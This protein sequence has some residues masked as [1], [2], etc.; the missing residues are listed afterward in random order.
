MDVFS[1]LSLMGGLAL[2]L[3]GMHVLGAGLEKIAGGKLERILEKMT[4]SPLKGVLLGAAVTAVIQSSSATTVMV[5][6]FVNS[7]IM[8]LTQSI[9][10][11]M[12][13]NIGTTVTAW[14]LSLT[15]LEGD[16]LLV[17]LLKP[18]SFTPVLA[19]IGIVLLLFVKRGRKK[20][21]G[22]TL[23][24]FAVLMFGM[25]MMS[26]S[27]KGLADV[28]AFQDL[29][30]MFQNPIFGVLVGAVVTAV[31]QSSSASV[32]ILQALSATGKITYGAAIPIILGQNIGTCATALISCIGANKNAKRAAMVHLYFNLI[33]TALFLALFYGLNALVDLAFIDNILNAAHIAVIHTLFNVLSTLVLL[34]AYKLLG[35]LA[36]ITIKDKSI[37]EIALFPDER[38]LNSPSFAIE[39]CR[40]STIKMAFLTKNTLL[41]SMA[42]LDNYTEKAAEEIEADENKTDMYEDKL[43]TYLVKLSSKALSEADSR[44]VSELLLSIGDFERISDHAVNIMQAAREM[45]EKG[46]SFSDEA[47]AELSIIGS[48]LREILDITVDSFDQNDPVLAA[49]VEPLEQVIDDLRAALK[50]R[51]ISRLQAGCCTIELGFIFSDILNNYE[52]VSDHCSNIAVCVIQTRSSA[53]DTHGYLRELKASGQPQF[54]AD[55]KSFKE[56]YLLP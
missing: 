18:E 48:A 19:V 27:V 1:F 55:Y 53:F 56:K 6:G 43:G 30:L 15:G 25:S 51:H 40:K 23:L 4:S 10:I 9:G 12:G 46:I 38:F 26:S 29:L 42:L 24:G 8:K 44:N 11:I 41:N 49:K 45:H 31:I 33:G 37:Q 14:I 34:P 54:T 50:T 13:A 16:G 35:K 52:R 7:G 28:P 3:Y 39:Q 20:D 22:S 21:I 2:F 47:K 36:E 17:R 32:G 5:V